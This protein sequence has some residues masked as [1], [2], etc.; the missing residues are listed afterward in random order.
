MLYQSAMINF[1]SALPKGL[2]KK[3]RN[4]SFPKHRIEIPFRML[5]C[6]PS[7][8]MKTNSLINLIA[9]MD[10]TFD[11]ITWVTR[12][13]SEPLLDFL[14]S[15]IPEDQLTIIEGVEN[16]PELES[17]NQDAQHLVI[18][19]DLVLSKDQRKISEYF[20]RARKVAKGVSVVYCSQDYHRTPKTIRINCGYI[21]LLKGLQ[22]R[23]IGLILSDYG[24]GVDKKIL[25][26]YYTYATHEKGN[27]LFIDTDRREFR[28]NFTDYFKNT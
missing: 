23:D 18:F 12:N 15:K 16:I 26:E 8:S 22:G 1:Y 13:A 20:I 2:Q 9:L 6:G 25:L 24:L 11:K 4:P 19:D 17:L 7:G 28:R 14:R 3:Y 5:I 27:M 21:M 10:E